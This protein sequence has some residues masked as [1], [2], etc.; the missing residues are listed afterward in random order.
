MSVATVNFMSKA[1]HRMITISAVFP[2]DKMVL[3]KKRLPERKPMKTLYYLEGSTSNYSKVITHTLIAPMAEDHNCCVIIVGGD[4]KYYGNSDISGDY[5][6][7]MIGED[8]IQFTRDT[9][10]LSDR[11]EDTFIGGFSMGGFGS[12]IV[13]LKYN[14]I[15]SH[16]INIDGTM[17]KPV[18]LASDEEMSADVFST[19]HY[20]TMFGLRDIKDYINSDQDYEYLAEQI[21]KNG[22]AKP[23]MLFSYGRDDGLIVGAR[24]AQEMFQGFGFEVQFEE[25]P[26]GHS[27]AC[28]VNHGLEKAFDWL[29]LDGFGDN[30]PQMG[31]VSNFGW[32]EFIGWTPY[33]TIR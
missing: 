21:D 9:F 19:T 4:D 32:D 25:V 2:T 10:H 12:L 23:K 7:K 14:D 8:L 5:Y 1:L 26:G 22:G 27:W 11:R 30:M 24:K 29:P 16:I 6:G 31:E 13:G 15:F 20:R 18:L 3:E 17:H 28:A 33:Y